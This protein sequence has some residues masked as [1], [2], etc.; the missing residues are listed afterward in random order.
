M[1][2]ILKLS[3]DVVARNIE[4]VGLLSTMTPQNAYQELG[5]LESD[6]GSE[7]GLKISLADFR[8]IQQAVGIDLH[9]EQFKPL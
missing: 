5:R 8:A 9:R 3:D 7:T 2:G 6:L 4:L 1:D